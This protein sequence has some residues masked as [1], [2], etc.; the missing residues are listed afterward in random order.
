MLLSSVHVCDELYLQLTKSTHSEPAGSSS[1]QTTNHR[2]A[3]SEQVH[4]Y[5]Y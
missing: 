3:E 4:A 2:T 1:Q 5:S